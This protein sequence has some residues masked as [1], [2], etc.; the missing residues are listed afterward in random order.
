MTQVATPGYGSIMS[1]NQPKTPPRQIRIGDDWYE[2]DE[3]AKR[4]NTE[5]AALVREFI[6]WYLRK[7]GAK[8]PERPAAIRAPKEANEE[9]PSS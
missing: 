3:A 4:M 6:A 8:L 5:R 1:P 9:R 7:P 2:F